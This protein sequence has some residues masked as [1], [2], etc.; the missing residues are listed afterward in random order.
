MTE[1]RLFESAIGLAGRLSHIPY[2]TDKAEDCGWHSSRN[3]SQDAPVFRELGPCRTWIP[4]E[5]GLVEDSLL[6][7]VTAWEK[8]RRQQRW[9]L[10]SHS[11]ARLGNDVLH[12]HLLEEHSPFSSRQESDWQ[13]CFFSLGELTDMSEPQQTSGALMA[14]TVTG[15]AN[16]ILCLAR[17]NQEHW[18]WPRETNVGIKLAEISD[19]EPALWAEE[20]AGPIHRVKCIVDPKPY[21]PTR[22]LAVQRDLGTTIFQPVYHRVPTVRSRDPR[23]DPSRIAANPLF[24]LSKEQTGGN[25]HTDVSFNPGTR[26]NPPQ[27]AIIDE[28][29]FWSV[30]NITLGRVKST[31]K[32][33]PRLKTCGHIERGVLEYLPYR[34]SSD[35]QWHKTVWVGRSDDRLDLFG[36]SGFDANADALES[37]GAFP[38]MQ[39]CSLLLMY[40]S[41][42]VRLLDVTAGSYLPD[43]ILVHQDSLDCVLDVQINPHD[44]Q[45]FYVLTTSRVFMV[46][47]YA[48]PGAEWNKP[49]RLWHILFSTPHFR[50]SF[51][52]G[53]KLAVTQGVSFDEA[54]FLVFIYSSANPWVDLFCIDQ[55]KKDASRVKYQRNV[56]GLES[57]QS[58]ALDNPIRGMWVSPAPVTADALGTLGR[59]ALD[60]AE[61]RIRFYQI[62]AL[63]SDMSLISTLCVSSG[64]SAT[65]ITAPT[66]KVNQPL[67]LHR[68][69]RRFVQH[70][71]S[72]FIVPDDLAILEEKPAL[73][74]TVTQ[75]LKEEGH[76]N[77]AQRF[78]KLFHE[79]LN[80]NIVKV[81]NDRGADFSEEGVFGSNPFDAA[82]LSVEE[83][84][85]KGPMPIR[86]LLQVMPGFEDVA[87]NRLQALEWEAEIERL[88]SIHPSITVSSFNLLRSS[89]GLPTSASLQEAYATL[90]GMIDSQSRNK[91]DSEANVEN[92]AIISQQ[93][94]Y[95]LH[96]SLY[97]IGYRKPEI[98][99]SQRADSQGLVQQVD[100]EDV[101]LTDSQTETL[102]SSPLRS[103]SP[104][105]IAWSQRSTSGA[106]EEE[107]TAMTLL[108]AYTG[109]GRFVPEKQFDL[110]NKWQLGAE[111][112]DYAFDLD[113]SNEAD[114]GK[115]RRARQLAR[116]SRKRR[117][118]ETLLQLS[119]E[120]ELPATQPA[121]DTSFFSSQPTGPNSQGQ[122]ILSDPMHTMSQPLPG[123]FG[124]RPKKKAKKRKGGF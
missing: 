12:E 31:G 71:S 51:D 14:V 33:V 40:N 50:N 52:R 44:P 100:A 124:K 69:R 1:R 27:L 53:L 93:I 62:A 78:I 59:T 75:C 74:P 18:K 8:S 106:V 46:R 66:K 54:T 35:M 81:L 64:L 77:T 87:G 60:I 105:S 41:Q 83:S 113:R 21:S 120:P 43:L 114:A 80:N 110:L 123:I 108:R 95:D 48:R 30:W 13:S 22:W 32:P 118:A 70:L 99:Q 17:L 7:S 45:Y 76:Q 103:Q 55:S 26:S 4:A 5:P 3:L 9:L 65:Q 29:G 10:K 37:Q 97:G 34:D 15:G 84:L 116:E 88:N 20:N 68:E 101:I 36:P 56:I 85:E 39:R 92:R 19:E 6:P 94:A 89:L 72:R 58:I 115:Q 73:S 11:E 16:D 23:K 67:R 28:R 49:E 117:R 2:G 91:D 102:P 79:Y 63:R 38:S 119:R 25:V 121:P 61:H 111:P 47:T 112:S 57:L 96:L 98:N 107:D 82:H 42:Q 122:L 104:G 24:H 109:T 90:L 86:T